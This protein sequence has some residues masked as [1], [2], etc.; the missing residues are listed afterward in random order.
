MACLIFFN[1]GGGWELSITNIIKIIFI[2]II[3]LCLFNLTTY[4]WYVIKRSIKKIKDFTFQV[5]NVEYF[6]FFMFY[7]DHG[8][9]AEVLLA[10]TST[11]L[12]DLSKINSLSYKRNNPFSLLS[13]RI[14]LLKKKIKPFA[15]ILFI[16]LKIS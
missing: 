9:M 7:T 11:P 1:G 5:F 12:P 3:I 14:L 4:I 15:G 13:I 2:V 16:K 10:L 6:I 8:G